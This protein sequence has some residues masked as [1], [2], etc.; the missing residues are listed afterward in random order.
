[1]ANDSA[2]QA[3]AHQSGEIVITEEMV[4]AGLSV[5]R[6]SGRLSSEADGPDQLLV[7]EIVRAVLTYSTP[8]TT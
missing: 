6:D 5:L 1:M 7:E 3:G 4:E 8:R 2:G